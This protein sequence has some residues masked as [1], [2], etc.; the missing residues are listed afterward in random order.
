MSSASAST[1]NMSTTSVSTACMSTAS[2]SRAYLDSLLGQQGVFVHDSGERLGAEVS[3]QVVRAS[4]RGAPSCSSARAYLSWKNMKENARKERTCERPVNQGYQ[5][6][7]APNV[8]APWTPPRTAGRGP[9]SP[10]CAALPGQYRLIVQPLIDRFS[11]DLKAN[12]T[13]TR[14]SHEVSDSRIV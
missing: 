13:L 7:H 6:W 12:K 2:T 8:T 9:S 10:D 5:C 11:G 4:G 14:C 1:T 3:R